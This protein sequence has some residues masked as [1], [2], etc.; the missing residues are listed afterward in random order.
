MFN[1]YDI[2]PLDAADKIGKSIANKEKCVYFQDENFDKMYAYVPNSWNKQELFDK[3]GIIGYKMFY[4]SVEGGGVTIVSPGDLSYL[5]ILPFEEN[6]FINN[7]VNTMIEFLSTK[8]DSVVMDNNDILINGYK[9]ITTAGNVINGMALF[10]STISFVDN[11]EFINEL[12]PPRHGKI[13][14][15]INNLV[16]NKEE[17]KIKIMQWLQ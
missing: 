2:T 13:P 11:S 4:D 3:Y 17:F 12:C 6:Q 7:F 5:I 8:F 14:K 15:P 10:M 1:F 16:I 9:S